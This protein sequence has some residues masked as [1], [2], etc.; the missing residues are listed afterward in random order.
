VEARVV[1]FCIQSR[2]GRQK[3]FETGGTNSSTKHLKIFYVPPTFSLVTLY[4]RGHCTRQGGHKD[5]QSNC[6]TKWSVANSALDYNEILR[7]I[8]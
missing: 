5:L 2:Q 8:N 6:A 7:N 3:Q 1:K 4:F